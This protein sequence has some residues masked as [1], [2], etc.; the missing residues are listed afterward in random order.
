MPAS[1]FELE[2]AS[3]EDITFIHR[4]GPARI[5]AENG[6]VVGLE[7]IGVISVFDAD[8]RFSPTFDADDRRTYEA[9]TVILAIGQA[10]DVDAI[11]PG[12]S[13]HFARKTIMVGDDSL[14]TSVDLVWAGGDAARGPRTLIEAIADGRSAATEIHRA[15]HRGIAG[16]RE[17]RAG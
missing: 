3:E 14:A 7:T 2:E 6:K 12:R 5:L 1:P 17:G 11:G 8:G 15:L 10:V 13:G 9:D 4:R 16:G